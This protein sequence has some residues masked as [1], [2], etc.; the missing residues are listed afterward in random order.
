MLVG[1]LLPQTSTALLMV[2]PILCLFLFFY[3][4]KGHV[5]TFGGKT[6]FITALVLSFIANFAFGDVSS[7][8]VLTFL[9]ILLILFCF[10]FIGDYKIR[11]I[12]FYI[13]LLFILFS[14][15]AIFMNIPLLS[16]LYKV[17]YP[18]SLYEGYYNYV[19]QNAGF[20]NIFNFRMSGIYHNPNQCARYVTIIFA[21]FILENRTQK[22]EKCLPYIA[23]TA[24]SVLM[25]GSR[26]GLFV[27]AAILLVWLWLND[28]VSKTKKNLVLLGIICFFAYMLY[29]SIGFRG[30]ELREGMDNSA[31]LKLYALLDYLKH[32]NGIM[33][34]LF[35]NFD[36]EKFER[37]SINI[38]GQMDSEYG[39]LIF[40]Y[41]FVAFFAYIYFFIA[42][43][44]KLTK[45]N[46]IMLI[47][48]LWILSSTMLLA[49]RPVFV[50]MLLLSKYFVTSTKERQL[51]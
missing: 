31:N 38:I 34:L 2:N 35:G 14:Q 1:L 24:L 46:R 17:L 47:P 28:S 18:P 4:R 32:D 6:V 26:T 12:Y 25:T 42:V 27:F 20:H 40:N 19:A 21:A 5:E 50:F 45:Y 49:F 29:S 13:A 10:P 39:Y 43:G 22:V 37:S 15:F 8:S 41:G 44:K 51:I 23:I 11:N 48:M 9:N 16:P 33:H 3:F 36:Q 7:K 30:I